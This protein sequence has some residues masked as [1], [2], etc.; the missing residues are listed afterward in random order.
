MALTAR[1]NRR[2]RPR[3]AVRVLAVLA[4][5]LAA[6]ACSG[7]DDE[8]ESTEGGGGS[9]AFPVTVEHAFGETEVTEEPERVVSVGVTEQDTI[10]A[11]GVIPVG[12][13]DW[14][15]DQPFGTWPWAQE[16]LGDAEPEVLSSADGFQYEK[17]A[18]LR[19]DLIIGTNA[20][21]DEDTYEKLTEIAPTVA[22]PEGGEGNFSAWDLQTLLIGQA[23][24][25]EAEAERMVDDVKGRFAEVAGAHPEWEGVEAIFLQNAFYDGEA[26]AYQDGLSTAFLTDLGFVVPPEIDAFHRE[27]DGSQA[28]IPMEQLPVL[29][30]ADLLIWGTEKAEDRTALEAEPLYDAL[31]EVRNGDLLFTDG[32]TAGAI[33]FTSVLSLPFV[34]DHLVPALEKVVGGEGPVTLDSY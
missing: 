2:P 32:L 33:Y 9:G 31:E 10:L 17:I 3:A 7:G 24:G 13:T 20:G 6:T 15:G 11:L 28:F 4:V 18:A 34:L 22:H 8:V 29:D 19:P 14:Y 26:I 25:R 12:V 1:S 27:E 16:A 5:A 21:I 23:L 30:T